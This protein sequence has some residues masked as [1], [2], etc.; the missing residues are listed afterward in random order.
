MIIFY[1][2]SYWLGAKTCISDGADMPQAYKAR[3]R[4]DWKL[5]EFLCFQVNNRIS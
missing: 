3:A 1:N 2:E 5:S 4:P